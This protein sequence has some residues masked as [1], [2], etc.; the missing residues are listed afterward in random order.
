MVSAW[1]HE[2]GLVLA[3]IVVETKSNEITAI[4]KLLEMLTLKGTIVT[5]D[6]LNCLRAIAQ[7][8]V[9]K[10]GVSGG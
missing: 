3:Q 4:P 7:T 6:A 8:I 9:D 5:V 2:Q 10:G 1:G